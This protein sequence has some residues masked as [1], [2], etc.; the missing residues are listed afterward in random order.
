MWVEIEFI[1]NFQSQ[2]LRLIVNGLKHLHEP[3]SL[4]LLFVHCQQF[5][6]GFGISVKTFI[7]LRKLIEWYL[8]YMDIFSVK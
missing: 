3:H 5:S 7:A 8:S 1:F 4:T 6:Y 2:I